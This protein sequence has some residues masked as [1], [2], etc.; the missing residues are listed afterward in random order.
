MRFRKKA[1]GISHAIK[2]AA[3]FVGDDKVLVLYGDN[4]FTRSFGSREAV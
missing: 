2:L 3:P 4:I 1:G